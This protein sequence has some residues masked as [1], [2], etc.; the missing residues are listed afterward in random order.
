MNSSTDTTCSCWLMLENIK[1]NIECFYHTFLSWQ[2]PFGSNPNPGTD[3]AAHG[4]LLLK[5][6][7]CSQQQHWLT[8]VGA[9]G[10]GF[11]VSRTICFSLGQLEHLTSSLPDCKSLVTL[12]HL[13]PQHCKTG[14][15]GC[16]AQQ[17]FSLTRNSAGLSVRWVGGCC[18]GFFFLTSPSL[19]TS[20]PV[21]P[22][23]IQLVRHKCS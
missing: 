8:L 22:N 20:L 1:N 3:L 4:E 23:H 9:R 7:V 5:G 18:L 2:L 6:S 15:F 13:L 21:L 14:P 11:P 17:D 12:Q 10:A 16:E 19:L